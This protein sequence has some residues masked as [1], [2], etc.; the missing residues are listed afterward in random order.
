[1]QQC[2]LLSYP[3][4][5]KTLARVESRDD[6]TLLPNVEALLILDLGW[7]FSVLIVIVR[8]K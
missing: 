7:D 2:A 3:V 4:A 8:R 5:R 6:A 1:M